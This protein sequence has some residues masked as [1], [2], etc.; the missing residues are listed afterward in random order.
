MSIQFSIIPFVLC[1]VI[2]FGLRTRFP[3]VYGS[4]ELVVGIISIWKAVSASQG[5]ADILARGVVIF[6][7]I[8][9]IVRGLD[10]MDKAVPKRLQG[11]WTLIR[12]RV[13]LKTNDKT[14]AVLTAAPLRPAQNEAEYMQ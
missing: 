4:G 8:Y 10:N 13:P 14:Q 7:G 9:I 3:F 2:L 12:W 11:I 1:G 5:D 6:G